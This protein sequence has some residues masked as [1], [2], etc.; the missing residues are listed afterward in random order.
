MESHVKKYFIYNGNGSSGESFQ[1]TTR[2]ITEWVTKKPV[3]SDV[4]DLETATMICNND[5][6]KCCTS[7]N[8]ANAVCCFHWK[9]RNKEWTLVIDYTVHISHNCY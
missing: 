6:Y 4:K 2:N 9:Y 3:I 1:K 7:C 5:K 8:N